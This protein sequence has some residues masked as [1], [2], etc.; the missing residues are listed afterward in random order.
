MS[1][2]NLKMFEVTYVVTQ[3]RTIQMLALDADHARQL[4]KLEGAEKLYEM[5][6]G[7]EPKEHDAQNESLVSVRPVVDVVHGI[8][9]GVAYCGAGRPT[10]WSILGRDNTVKGSKWSDDWNQ[11]TCQGCIDKAKQRK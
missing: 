7:C 4:F 10:Q 1:N 2:P 9:G 11:V 3:T 5:G 6:T 8:R